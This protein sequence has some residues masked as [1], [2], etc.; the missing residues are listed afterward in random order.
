MRTGTVVCMVVNFDSARF[1]RDNGTFSGSE[2]FQIGTA[3]ISFFGISRRSAF[4]LLASSFKSSF[5]FKNN[6][7]DLWEI[8]PET[9][10]LNV[11]FKLL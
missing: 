4:K 9:V 10:G 2:S 5:M 7:I 1:G 3:G 8:N 6:A 11:D